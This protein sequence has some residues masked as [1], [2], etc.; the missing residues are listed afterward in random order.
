MNGRWLAARRPDV[1]FARST[2]GRVLVAAEAA[3]DDAERDVDDRADVERDRVEPDV[4]RDDVERVVRARL[5]AE[6]LL[7]VDRRES[8]LMA[9]LRRST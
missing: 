4:A 5:D 6:R 7:G 8:R 2:R 1:R 3:R 9:C